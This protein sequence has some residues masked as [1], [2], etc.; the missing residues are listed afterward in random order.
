[1]SAVPPYQGFLGTWVLI[2]ESCDYEQSD[3]PM[4]G[5]Y[6]IAAARGELRF[7]IE[8]TDAAGE[9][10]QVAFSG[11]PDGKI[12]PFSGGDLADALCVEAVSSRELTTRAFYRGI[13]RMVAQRQLDERGL[14]M[15]VI[16]LVRFADGDK[17]TN[18]GIYRK[19]VEN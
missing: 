4:R 2:P 10:H 6:R 15:R 9:T 7:A 12:V 3:P 18:V 13:E 17:A 8:W 14:A 11:V 5:I 19:Q 16:Q 1:M